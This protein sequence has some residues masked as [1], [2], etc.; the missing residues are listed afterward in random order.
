MGF[1]AGA[2]FRLRSTSSMVERFE[3]AV[4]PQDDP[5][6]FLR[7]VGLGFWL[8]FRLGARA[9]KVDGLVRGLSDR[10]LRHLVHDGYGFQFGF[11]ELARRPRRVKALR[12]LQG[13][14]RA[15]AFNGLGRSLWF[16]Y[17]DRPEDGF[18]RARAF[19]EDGLAVFGGMGLAAAFTRVDDLS[20]AYAVADLLHEDER[21][22]FEKGI[23]IALY[24]RHESDP[25]YLDE[26][27]HG[28][29]VE[30]ASRVRVDIAH[31]VSVGKA[32]ASHSD[33]I[34][35]FHAGCL[36]APRTSGSSP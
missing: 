34:E 29:P 18:L 20:R 14:G 1:G 26:C 21:R 22:A 6:R 13:F 23:R 32:T 17:M 8:G 36:D 12:R 11:F 16:F 4:V 15:S 28:L 3:T 5:S 19:A 33:F 24:C 27:L 7:Y 31:A 25:A 30:L 2:L 9:E 10:R 35:V